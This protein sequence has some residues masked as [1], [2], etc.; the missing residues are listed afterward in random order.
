M[1]RSKLPMNLRKTI[2]RRALFRSGIL[3]PLALK[4][5]AKP[6]NAEVSLSVGALFSLTGN[7]ADLG[8]Q[9]KLMMEIAAGDLEALLGDFSARPHTKDTGVS[10]DLMFED[11]QLDPT[12]AANAAESLI[13]RGAQFLIG[14]QT[15]AEVA[16]VKPITDA[17]GVVLVSQGSTASSLSIPNDTVFR[18]VP[19]DTL[20]SKAIAAAA[21]GMGIKAMVPVWRGD[22]GNQGLVASL[23]KFGP[24]LGITVATGFEYPTAGANFTTVATELATA[25]GNLKSN[26]PLSQIAVFVAGFDEAA[27]LLSAA[28]AS[29]DLSSVRWFATD[30][31]ALSSAFLAPGPAQFAEMTHLAAA[32]L[33]LPA[34]AQPLRD[35]ILQAT[36]LT[37]PIPFA[38]AAYDAFVCATLAWLLAGEERTK[39][40]DTLAPVAK[41][42]FGTTG[43]ALLDANGDRAIGSFEF[44]GIVNGSGG[45]QWTGLFSQQV[46]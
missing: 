36:G 13:N 41:Q 29:S 40:R 42:H 34:E 4:L 30:G 33:G 22:A 45:P 9:S 18:F 31:I 14:P 32:N 27:G 10:F 25:V 3:S 8:T 6:A 1:V 28:S 21:G 2:S 39:V 46:S 43:W 44:F 19:D 35:P 38:F 26:L 24:G 23:Q 11:T 15:S 7:S 5:R 37:S 17:A 12:M 16:A 20:E